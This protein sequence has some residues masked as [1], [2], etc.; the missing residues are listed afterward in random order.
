[1]RT[2]HK[3]RVPGTLLLPTGFKILQVGEQHDGFFY[4]WVEADF[5]R[6]EQRN[7]D[8]QIL[9]TGWSIPDGA[10]HAGTLFSGAFVWHVYYK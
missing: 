10:T 7:V 8:F 6:F 9:G 4:I 2:I 3:Y 5:D 1:M